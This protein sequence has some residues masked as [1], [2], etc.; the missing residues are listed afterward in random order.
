M[1]NSKNFTAAYKEAFLV[2]LCL[3]VRS[4]KVFLEFDI[5]LWVISFGLLCLMDVKTMMCMSRSR[6]LP[7][8]GFRVGSQTTLERGTPS[9]GSVGP[10]FRTVTRVTNLESSVPFDCVNDWSKLGRRKPAASRFPFKRTSVQY[11]KRRSKNVPFP[12]FLMEAEKTA[13]N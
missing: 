6:M 5:I 4:C 3:F 1:S 8:V 7:Y 12:P 9:G 2:L 13:D 10:D 11:Q